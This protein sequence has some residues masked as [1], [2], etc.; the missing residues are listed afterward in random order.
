MFMEIAQVVSKRSTCNRKHVGAVLIK[1][2]RVIAIGY[3]GVLPGTNPDEGIDAEGNSKTVHA[4]ANIIAF[5][6]KHGISTQ[7]AELYITLSPCVKCSELI[8]QAGIKT[9]CYL[10][11]YRNDEG[12]Q[13][14]RKNNNPIMI[15][16][17]L[18]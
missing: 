5:C 7:G 15:Y 8:M 1:D 18:I 11:P 10:E 17:H 4:E 3:N 16:K 9:V 13:L 2:N 6:A 14:I 12:I